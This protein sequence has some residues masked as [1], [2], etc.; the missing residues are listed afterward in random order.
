MSAVAQ[1]ISVLHL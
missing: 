1:S